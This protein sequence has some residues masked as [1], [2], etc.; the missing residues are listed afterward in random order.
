MTKGGHL[1]R[2][3]EGMMRVGVLIEWENEASF[4]D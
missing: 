1:M 4:L 3:G 2:K